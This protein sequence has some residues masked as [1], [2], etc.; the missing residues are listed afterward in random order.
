MGKIYCRAVRDTVKA[1]PCLMTIMGFLFVLNYIGAVLP[2]ITARLIE[3]A[4]GFINGSVSAPAVW[5]LLMLMCVIYAV[6]GMTYIIRL[7][8][9]EMLIQKISRLFQLRLFKKMNSIPQIL[10]EDSK[11]FDR[12]KRAEIATKN[13]GDN[14]TNSFQMLIGL[15]VNMFDSVVS[16]AI[17]IIILISFS[18]YLLIFAILSTPLSML[19]SI[20]SERALKKLRHAQTQKTRETEYLWGLFCKKESVKEMRVF[21]ASAFLRGKWLKKRDEMI[22]EEVGVQSRIL[23]F[24]NGGDVVKNL[25]YGINIALAVV[26]MIRGELS[27]GEFTACLGLFG[28]LQTCLVEFMY[29]IQSFSESL[30]MAQE[31]Y[32]FMDLP[33]KQDGTDECGG[34]SDNIML[35]GVSF[36]YPNTEK[37]AINN[38][39]L[40]IKKGEHI[41]VVGENGSG[42]T[43]LSKLITSCYEPQSGNITIDGQNVN[44]LKRRSYLKNFSIVS[45]NFVRYNMTLR[46]N[47]AMSDTTAMYDEQR[48]DMAAGAAGFDGT[49]DMVGGYDTQIGREFGGTELSGG[50]WQKLAVARGLF[51]DAPIIILDEPTAAL[52]PLVEYEILTDFTEMIRNRTSVI[53]SH[54]IGICTSADRIIVMKDGYVAEEGTHEELLEKGGEYS[55]MWSAQAD[56]YN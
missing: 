43:T 35:S 23:M 52:D 56:W 17:N 30:H 54:R 9:N 19:I 8:I 12:Y 42:K 49:A 37:P 4:Q 34:F 20:L 2:I 26:L 51:R 15:S 44:N 1:S 45:Q 41:V 48:L 10:L 25:F 6:S 31:Y 55:R 13:T 33:D 38:I 5:H 27:I 22:R 50:Q 24:S 47:V 32:E 3:A 40:T 39:N 46:E 18:P 21:G 36:R 28:S 29:N 53:I 11:H 16:T 14:G 7:P